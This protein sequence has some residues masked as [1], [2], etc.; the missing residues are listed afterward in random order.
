MESDES[1]E[2]DELSPAEALAST[3][4]A[5]EALVRR[6]DVPWAW[7]AFTAVGTG[8]FMWL[9]VEP[10]YPWLFL[11]LAPWPIAS[12]WM[13]QARQNRVGVA[14]DGVKRRTIGHRLWRFI[15]IVLAVLIPAAV[16]DVGWGVTRFTPVAVGVSAVMLYV[17]FRGVNRSVIAAIR[18]AP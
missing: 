9:M 13:R 3:E 2:V 8:L 5:R 7:D 18:D 12:V 11:V 14:L 10:P 17:F 1:S 15:G 16:L 4:A 6:V